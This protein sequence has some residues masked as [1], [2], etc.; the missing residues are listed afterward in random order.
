MDSLPL[1]NYILVGQL[2]RDFILPP[3]QKPLLDI[4][5]G[6]LL[7][8]AIGLRIWQYGAGLVSR[9]G[10]D[11]P[12]QWL[13]RLNSYGFDTRGIRIIPKNLDLRYFTAYLDSE[14]RKHDSP[15]SH[16]AHTGIP[17]SKTLLGYT[18]PVQSIDSRTQPTD[19]TI[20]H[21]DIPEDYLDA[22]AAHICPIDFLTHSLLPSLLRQ[23][24]I[25]TI[26]L[27]PS[28]GYMNPTF[29]NDLPS[30]VKGLTVFMVSEEKMNNL[31]Q[32]RSTD[33]WEMAEAIS[34]YG[35]E[36]VVIKR[37]TQGQYLYVQNSHT[38]W[39]IP[40]YPANVINPTGAGDAFCGGFLGGYRTTYDPLEAAIQGNISSSM[41][42]EGDD[43][44]YALD[45]LPGLAQMRAEALKNM[46][47]K[48]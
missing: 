32:G 36:L 11:Y 15:V 1:F 40:A 39:V 47:R 44:F 45:A 7:Y 21:M 24:H 16:F 10:E 38:R 2:K 43:P 6:N 18:P 9:V 28:N 37:K 30:V 33:L 34:A 25:S 23:G 26:S 8:S 27:E 12:H 41:V 5:G 13:D 20:R 31:F 35:C 48:I 14:T 4:P 46:V 19:F 42:I 29:W 22:T 17:F 3:S